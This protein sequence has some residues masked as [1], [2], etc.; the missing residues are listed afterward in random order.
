MDKECHF[1]DTWLLTPTYKFQRRLPTSWYNGN[2]RIS[3]KH[4][5]KTLNWL[6]RDHKC[7]ILLSKRSNPSKLTTEERQVK[8]LRRPG[9]PMRYPKNV[10]FHWFIFFFGNKRENDHTHWPRSA[11]LAET[12]YDSSKSIPE[13]L[14]CTTVK[15]KKPTRTFSIYQY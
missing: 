7:Q 8:Q 3:S 15:E 4:K 9:R 13:P 6:P 1:I 5:K 10:V 14:Q 2:L 11:R 12:P